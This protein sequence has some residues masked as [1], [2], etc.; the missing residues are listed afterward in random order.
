MGL[1]NNVGASTVS[2]PAA[3]KQISANA[4]SYQ[5][6][7]TVPPGRKFTGYAYSS[8]S[9]FTEHGRI[10]GEGLYWNGSYHSGNAPVLMAAGATFTSGGSNSY[11]HGI[12]EDA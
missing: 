5:N 4:S 11:L 1:T 10:N 2:G 6:M 3:P 9:S 8:S 12:E 7:Y